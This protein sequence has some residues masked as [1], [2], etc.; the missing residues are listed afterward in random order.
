VFPPVR[1]LTLARRAYALEPLLVGA[2]RQA[3][4]LQ[5]VMVAVVNE[6]D[7]IDQGSVEFEERDVREAA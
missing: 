4:W 5:R 2:C 6:P 7:E 3:V 1:E